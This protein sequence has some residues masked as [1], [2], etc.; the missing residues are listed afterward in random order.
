MI[1]VNQ[2]RLN[3]FICLIFIIF[4]YCIIFY[5]IIFKLLPSTNVFIFFI[6]FTV[7]IL[8]T[9]RT[10]YQRVLINTQP[11]PCVDTFDIE[12]RLQEEEED[13]E[14][15]SNNSNLSRLR[16]LTTDRDFNETDYEELLKL[17]D[18]NELKFLKGV[19][20]TETS[21]L[22][23]IIIKENDQHLEKTCSICLESF[24]VGEKMVTIPCF[25][26]F[27]KECISQ[28]LHEKANCPICDKNVFNQE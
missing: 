13:Q 25:H 16:L 27:H 2:R 9:I 12:N 28:W 8:S 21:R 23:F 15:H 18:E 11:I 10:I 20:E 14:I 4:I 24:K 6:L 5:T 17:D 7:F 22:P 1:G 26:Q 19:S 3:F